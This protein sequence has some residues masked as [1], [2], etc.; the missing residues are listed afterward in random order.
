MYNAGTRNRLK[1]ASVETVCVARCNAR[2]VC[3]L[4]IASTPRDQESQQH[5]DRLM[6]LE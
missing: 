1:G 4:M 3:S 6:P 2:V 5:A